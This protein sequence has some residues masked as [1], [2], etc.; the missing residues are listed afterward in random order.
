MANNTNK[1]NT[2]TEAEVTVSTTEETQ[3]TEPTQEVQEAEAPKN[4]KKAPK[5]TMVLDA[6]GNICLSSE[7]SALDAGYKKQEKAAKAKAE[8]RKK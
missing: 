2:P 6:R 1:N 4:E 8:A 7:K 3:S 5:N